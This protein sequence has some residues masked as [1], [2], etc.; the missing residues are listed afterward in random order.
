MYSCLHRKE[1]KVIAFKFGGKYK[2][3]PPRPLHSL[4]LAKR[5]TKKQIN[6]GYH[7]DYLYRRTLSLE[8]SN[9]NLGLRKEPEALV[10][11]SS[12]PGQMTLD[13]GAET[14]MNLPKQDLHR[15]TQVILMI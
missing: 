13:I 10:Q 4:S 9:K 1:I 7:Y 11:T 3:L 14:D 8:G 2:V 5:G 12:A 15:I 6:A